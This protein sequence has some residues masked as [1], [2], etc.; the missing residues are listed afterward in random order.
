[1]RPQLRTGAPPHG[2]HDSV[3]LMTQCEDGPLHAY[4]LLAERQPRG[5]EQRGTGGGGRDTG[6]EGSGAARGPSE[7]V[8]LRLSRTSPRAHYKPWGY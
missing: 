4:V 1:M 8:R 5:E 7:T 2:R 6:R 3:C